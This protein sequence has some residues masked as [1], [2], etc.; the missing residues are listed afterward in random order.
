[1]VFRVLV[2]LF[3]A[4]VL[5]PLSLLAAEP[6]PLP[7]A[8]PIAADVVVSAEA[9]PEPSVSLGAAATVIDAAEIAR[10]KSATVLDLLRAVPGL[11]VVQSGGAGGVTSL[12]LRGASSTQTLVLLDGVTL[13]SPYFGGTDLSAISTANVERIEIVRG[14]F[15]ALYGSEAIGGVV[16]IFTRRAADAGVSGRASFALGNA[17]GKEGSLEG[18]FSEGALSATFAFRRTLS[19]GDPFNEFFSGTTLSGAL[20]ARL[21]EGATAGVVLRRDTGR[22]GIPTD[23]AVPTPQRS[24]SGETTAVEIPLSLSLSKNLSLSASVRYVRDRPGYADPADPFFTSSTTDA[25]RA[26]GRVAAS[27]TWG[28]HRLAVGADVERTQVSS[29]SNFGVALD[30]ATS[31]TLALFAEDRVALAGEKLVATAGVRWDDAS[32]YGSAASPRVTIAWRAL[33]SLK[34][35]AAAGS[36]FRAPSLGELYYPYSGSPNLRPE[37]STGWEV[38]GELTLA[39]GVVGEVTG[40]WNDIRDL[41]QY[42]ARTFSNANVGHARTRGVEVAVRTAVGERAFLRASYTYLDAKDLA[43]DAPLIRRPRNR[44]SLTAGSGFGKGG[45]WSVTGIFVGARDDR[46][47]ADFTTVVESPS[48]FRLDA[49]VTLPPLVWSLSPWVRVTNVFNREYAE[50]NGFPA[51][52]RRYLAGIE[53]S[54]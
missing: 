17:G 28:A 50:V 38:G 45:S 22:T 9:A 36:A 12:F 6:A 25:R 11:D 39:E 20:T 35:R 33:A 24:T 52:S 51:P 49:A 1:M 54:F 5:C 14:P 48:Y 3:L 31:R 34:L 18:G 46:D 30:G 27:G 10:S 8:A 53:A 37:R 44:A 16:Q 40:F 26:G 41:I 13:N 42:D 19:S 7:A 15:S 21:G 4:L 29:E 2:R 23:G 32:S 43:L 47:A